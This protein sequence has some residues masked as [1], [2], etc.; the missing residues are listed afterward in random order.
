MFNMNII[1]S[2]NE[3]QHAILDRLI[4]GGEVG[5]RELA[6]EF[7]VTGMTIRRDFDLLEKK[8]LIV[9]TH[10]GAIA[11]T[12]LRLMKGAP[13]FAMVSEA[14]RAIGR[15]AAALVGQ[16][17]TVMVDTGT[18]ALAVAQV[19]PRD[20]G[21]TVATTS[22]LVAQE[23]YGSSVSVLVIGGKLREHFP[24]TYGS[25]AQSLLESLRV[26]TLF[27][28]CDAAGGVEGFYTS[29]LD[30]LDQETA[31]VRAAARVVVVAESSKFGRRGLVRYARPDDIAVLVTDRGLP[32][33]DRLALTGAKVEI[34]FADP[35]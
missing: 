29:D 18:T 11:A 14:K 17:E 7:D 35:S 16:G 22:L 31:M 27:I 24:S 1:A 10:G 33:A 5:V 15:A 32:E 21:I 19:L 9:R 23:L 25:V 13:E 12:G 34:V 28:G 26:D 2:L 4:R 30:L 6:S 3:R 20:A 8:N